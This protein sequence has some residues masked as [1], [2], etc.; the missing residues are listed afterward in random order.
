MS[1][2]ISELTAAGALTGAELV[3]VVQSSASRRTTAQAIANLVT[4]I[5]GSTGSTDNAVI[6]ADG[7]GGSTVQASALFVTDDGR[8]YGTAIHNNAN[9]VTGTTNQYVASGTWSPTITAIT[10]ISA[11]SSQTSQ[12][13]RVGNVVTLSGSVAITPT[14]SG[15]TTEIRMSLPIA[16]NFTVSSNCAGAANNAIGTS[17]AVIRP[18]TANDE[19]I[20]S[21]QSIGTVN[22]NMYFYF[23]YVIL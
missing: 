18:D 14:A 6:R 4:G 22:A 9:P 5:G 17:P 7:T 19:A 12:W 11:S 16:S 2:K 15:T 3:E 8:L 10:N 21:F 1:K 13:I 20:L 23:S